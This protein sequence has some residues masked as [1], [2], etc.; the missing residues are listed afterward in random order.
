MIEKPRPV[1]I[2]ET[3]EARAKH[4][5]FQGRPVRSFWESIERA[6]G[7]PAHMVPM[8]TWNA[9]WRPTDGGDEDD[10]RM[11]A[12]IAYHLAQWRLSKGIYRTPLGA[13]AGEVG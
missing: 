4:M 6:T 11:A 13:S 1:A 3:F 12:D 5:Q 7:L 2:L 8:A 10:A 9:A